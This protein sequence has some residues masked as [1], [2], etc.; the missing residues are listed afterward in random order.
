MHASSMENMQKAYERYVKTAAWDN[1]NVIDVIDVGGANVNGSYAD[2]FSTN[3][4]HYRAVDIQESD[5][6]DV[7]LDD[8]YRLPFENESIDVLISGQAFEHVE[9]FWKLFAEMCRVLRRDGLLILIAPSSGPIHK[10]PVDCYRFYP[11]AYAALAK[12][13]NIHLIDVWMDPRGPWKDLV[14]VFSKTPKNAYAY[15]QGTHTNFIND[16]NRFEQATRP[17]FV[18]QPHVLPEAEVTNGT[19][20]YLDVLEKMHETLNPTLYLEIGVRNGQSL[21]RSTCESIG[22]DPLP[23]DT[24]KLTSNQ[25]I[26]PVRSDDFFEFH[27]K[28]LLKDRK[29]DLAFIDGMHLFEFALRDFINI[30]KFA[31]NKTII[32][33]DDI[34]PS[35]PIQAQ[36]DRQSQVWTGDIWKLKHCLEKHRPDLNI[37]SLDTAPTGLLVISGLKPNN[38]KLE[39][40][41]NPIVREYMNLTLQEN[42]PLFE[43]VDALSPEHEGFWKALDRINEPKKHRYLM[44]HLKPINTQKPDISIIVI[45]FNMS[46]ELPRTLT[47]LQNGYQK[48]VKDIKIEIIVVDNGSTQPLHIPDTIKN[49]RLLKVTTPTVSPVSAINMGL[50]EAQADMI[51]VFID[52][53]RMASPGIIKYVIQAMKLSKRPIVS[54]LG[55]HLGPDVQLRSMKNGYS[56]QVEDHILSTVPW[57]ENGYTLFDISVLAG[58]SRDGWFKPIAESNALFM[59]KAMWNELGGYETRFQTLGGG[60]VNLDTYVRALNLPASDFFLLLGEGTFHQI[61]GGIA[62]NQKRPDATWEVFENEYIKIRGKKFTKPSRPPMYLGSFNNINNNHLS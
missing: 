18:S 19:M 6:V 23:S 57:Q 30:E 44:S 22:V 17:A 24:L 16:F 41:Y 15:T 37:V 61:H 3:V 36:R 20:S 1:R 49:V 13:A 8:P 48:G 60:L 14:G 53:A 51:G 26:V 28:S 55:F 29:V 56:E 9:F 54:T 25:T 45:N 32:V 62:T 35:H 38:T 11:D 59:T 50:K 4:F 7:V 21:K 39:S 34:Y 46:R 10:Y 2:V 27:S 58:S 40:Q 5:G 12:D 33:I 42:D 47:T 52:G 31:S 43:R